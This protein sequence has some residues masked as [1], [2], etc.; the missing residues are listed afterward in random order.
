[1]SGHLIL[2]G[3][4]GLTGYANQYAAVA[5]H[6]IAAGNLAFTANILRG[7]HAVSVSAFSGAGWLSNDTW[8]PFTGIGVPR[9]DA[10]LSARY[11]FSGADGKLLQSFLLARAPLQLDVFFPFFVSQPLPG[12]KQLAMR[13]DIGVSTAL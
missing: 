3:G 5:A 1:M 2:P 10:G 7:A 6:S 9:F 4:G 11:A 13:W 8:T 12:E